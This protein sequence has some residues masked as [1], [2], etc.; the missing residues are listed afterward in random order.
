VGNSPRASGVSRWQI[1]FMIYVA[2][3]IAIG[4]ALYAAFLAAR[5]KQ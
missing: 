3:I 1:F 4:L 5:K 2:I